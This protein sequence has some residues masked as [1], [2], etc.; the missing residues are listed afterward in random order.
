MTRAHD[1]ARRALLNAVDAHCRSDLWERFE[2]HLGAHLT[3]P[4]LLLYAELALSEGDADQALSLVE[5]AE[6]EGSYAAQLMIGRICRARGDVTAASNALDCALALSEFE[7]AKAVIRAE[8]AELALADG[9]TEEAAEQ[10][11][12]ALADAGDAETRLFARNVLGKTLIADGNWRAATHHFAAD[13]EEATTLGRE[14]DALR[15][16]LNRAI[17]VMWEGR[18]LEA[19]ALLESILETGR[20]RRHRR[21]IA[22]AL[23]NLSTYAALVHDYSEALILVEQAIKEMHAL[24]DSFKLARQ[25]MNLAELR[26]RVGMVEEAE[27]ALAFGRHACGPNLGDAL[28]TM[29]SIVTAK[30]K[31]ASADTLKAS[32]A[33]QEAITAASRSNDGGKLGQSLR[34]ARAHRPRGRQPRPGQA[35]RGTGHASRQRSGRRGGSGAAGGRDPAGLRVLLRR[36]RH[37]GPRSR[38]RQQ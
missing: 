32:M 19:R 35:P 14:T 21:T 9:R 23:A 22:F 30:V 24:G 38:K 4:E 2:R 7:H 13:E 34:I 25:I 36:R 15:A 11:R 17:A 12:Q 3:D 16:R 1:H 29:M 20:Q 26:L 37:P 10:A 33:I 6:Q 18:R 8:L 28:V 31:L 27:Q 5:R